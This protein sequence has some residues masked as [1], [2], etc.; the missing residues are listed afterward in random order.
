MKYY[1]LIGI[2][3]LFSFS[4]L[5]ADDKK[6]EHQPAKSTTA[7]ISIPQSSTSV[8]KANTKTLQSSCD[9]ICQKAKVLQVRKQYVNPIL[10]QIWS[11]P[12][13]CVN[14]MDDAKAFEELKGIY[15]KAEK[16]G[17]FLKFW[18]EEFSHDLYYYGGITPEQEK[19]IQE[20]TIGHICVTYPNQTT[21][22]ALVEIKDKYP[23]SEAA[24]IALL[25][26]GDILVN[27][28]YPPYLQILNIDEDAIS[29]KQEYIKVN[30][31]LLDNYTNCW[32]KETAKMRIADKKYG[33]DSDEMIQAE[34]RWIN[35]AEQY[36]VLQNKYYSYAYS[37][38]MGLMSYYGHLSRVYLHKCEEY[39]NSGIKKDG[40]LPAEAIE[41][42]KKHYDLWESTKTKYPEFYVERKKSRHNLDKVRAANCY[43][44]IE[45]YA[46][47]Q[48]KH[49]PEDIIRSEPNKPIKRK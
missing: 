4:F 9:N 5:H 46:P 1:S 23:C 49:Q 12:M 40:K 13:K 41:I 31:Y 16:P 42:Y 3:V 48:V 15:A 20:G 29:F 6:V 2:V 11:K 22:Q 14:L 19:Q 33:G 45:Q 35:Y 8:K 7:P 24:T 30:Q 26:L 21:V 18:T 32:E 39:A 38:S 44:L 17:Q 36:H 27:P 43:G 37:S 25:K 10:E 34:E 28:N 47:A